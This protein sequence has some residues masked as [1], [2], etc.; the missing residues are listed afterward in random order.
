MDN[1]KI[2][3]AEVDRLRQQIGD[4]SDSTKKSLKW[5]ELMRLVSR[6]PGKK[7]LIISI[8]LSMLTHF[9]GN[10]VLITYTANIFNMAGSVL[11]PNE[12][13]LIVAGVQFVA[14]C[15]VTVLIERAGRKP[16]YIVSTVGSVIGLSVLGVYVMLKMWH[17]HVESFSWIPVVGLS[18]TVFVQALAIST[19]S[20]TVVAE[21]LPDSLRECGVPFCNGILSASAFVVLKCT[22]LL[23]AL[24]GLHGLFFFFAGYCGLSTLFIAFWVPEPKG[25]TY[26][27]IMKSLE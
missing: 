21:I 7:A 5:S 17:Y 19:L 13:A 23:C 22:P 14:T 3:D 20:M 9:S 11:H 2:I 12:S 27:E 10:F 8:V 1:R 15:M 16:L 4:Q 18:A 26:D 25:K 6:N 24:V